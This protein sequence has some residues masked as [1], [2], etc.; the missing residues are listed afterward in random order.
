MKYYDWNK[1]A[2]DQESFYKGLALWTKKAKENKCTWQSLLGWMENINFEKQ[3]PLLTEKILSAY[4][5][6]DTGSEF[7]PTHR[8]ITEL[9]FLISEG[10]ANES[11][12]D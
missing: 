12:C 3:H 11:L 7:Y 6:F 8:V 1:I 9:A 4:L 10:Y 2:K 5:T